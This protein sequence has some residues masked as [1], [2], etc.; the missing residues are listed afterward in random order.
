MTLK[1]VSIGPS[2][3]VEK[4]RWALKLAG[5][6]YEEDAHAPI[7]HVPYV[8]LAGGNRTVPVLKTPQG[9][10]SDSTD[11]L[12]WIDSRPESKWKPYPGPTAAKIRELEDEFDE[13]LGPHTRRVG[14]FHLL[15]HKALAIKTMCGENPNWEGKTIELFYDQCAAMMRKTM[16]IDAE[17]A[18]RSTQKINEVFDRAAQRLSDGR[19]YLMGEQLTAADITLASL[20][21]PVILPPQ[22]GWSMPS[23][24]EAPTEFRAE[25]DRYRAHPA[26]QFI[27]RL[28]EN[29]R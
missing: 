2:H 24:D 10:W 3:Y 19:P 11:I 22:Y 15:P 9:V 26:G 27:L 7:F 1:L 12:V 8:K 29:S 6:S 25:I 23:I 13:S 18:A 20:G 4:I 28:Y 5:Y 14:Y 16:R 17:G 21:A